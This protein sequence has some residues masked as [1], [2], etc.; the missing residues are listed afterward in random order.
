MKDVISAK[1]IMLEPI[2]VKTL[3]TIRKDLM[4]KED[5]VGNKVKDF[6]IKSKTTQVNIDLIF[7]NT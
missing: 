2:Q 4:T 6:E 7:Y 3:E 5:D 1:Q